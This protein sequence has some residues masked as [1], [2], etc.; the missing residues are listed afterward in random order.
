MAAVSISPDEKIDTLIRVI[1]AHAGDG[2]R[3]GDFEL[4]HGRQYLSHKGQKSV[5]DVVAS[6]TQLDIIPK[7]KECKELLRK[8]IVDWDGSPVALYDNLGEFRNTGKLNARVCKKCYDNCCLRYDVCLKEAARK[9][10]DDMSSNNSAMVNGSWC[11]GMAAG[12][13]TCLAATPP[14]GA[15]VM[16]ASTAGCLGYH[17]VQ[18][19]HPIGDCLVDTRDCI[20][21]HRA[22]RR[23]SKHP[24]AR[25]LGCF[26]QLCGRGVVAPPPKR[27]DR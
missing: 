5:K 22:I 4:S 11:L 2:L 18:L 15:A 6:D 13:I 24:D 1:A 23:R 14:A 3:P 19:R 7:C 12:A 21:P 27:S 26:A 8:P 10:R 16:G 17:A 25:E 9:T 20:Q